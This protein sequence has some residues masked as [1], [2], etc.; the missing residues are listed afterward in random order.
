MKNLPIALRMLRRNAHSGEARVLAAA[1][2]VAVAS[3]TTVGFFADRV[4]GALDR[5]ANE[6]LGGDLVVIADHPVPAAFVERARADGLAIAQTTT[7]PSMVAGAASTRASPEWALRRSMRS[8]MG[9]F[10]MA[11][12]GVSLGRGSSSR[13]SR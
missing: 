3:V 11:G 13:R 10:F 4:R 9:R 6:L 7:F 2:L 5:Q 12:N 1:L 8:A